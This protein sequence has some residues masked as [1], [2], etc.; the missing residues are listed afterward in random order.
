MSHG[1]FYGILIVL[2]LAL[3]FAWTIRRALDRR[4]DQGEMLADDRLD[5]PD[6]AIDIFP[7]PSVPIGEI[8]E[9]PPL[10]AVPQPLGPPDDLT[11]LK[12]LGTRAQTRL[13][14][15]GILRYDQMASW[16]EADAAAID[17]HMGSFQGRIARDRWVD[18][19]RF[20]A[21]GDTEGFE[22]AF[23]KLG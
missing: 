14:E 21:T 15:M 10:P 12:G 22:A 23:G 2:L 18:Q 5:H 8:E 17:A 1:A 16:T 9:A 4:S 20:L 6:E 19:A 7:G 13:N 3:G 11:R